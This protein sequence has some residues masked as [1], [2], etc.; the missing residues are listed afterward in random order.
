MA[1]P[2]TTP[3]SDGLSRTGLLAVFGA[4]LMWGAFPLYFV[5]TSP[6]SALEVVAWRVV[7]S[8]IFCAILLVVT[9]TWRSF[10][11]LVRNGSLMARLFV[12]GLLVGGNWLI[13]VIAV[14]SG[15][16]LEASLGYF[17][18]PLVSV[19]LGVVVLHEKLRK[20]QWVAVG[21]ATVAVLAMS[22]LYGQVPWLALGLAFTFGFYGLVKSRLGKGVTALNSLSAETLLL[23]PIALAVIAFINAQGNLTLL[24]E[25]TS[26]FWVLA[27]S[28]IVT[29]VPL[30]CFAVAAANLPLSVV[31]MVQYMTPIMQFLIAL[32]FFHEHMSTERWLGFILVWVAVALFILDALRHNQRRRVHRRAQ[33]ASTTRA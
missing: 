29:G 28:G 22:I 11:T 9:G 10:W 31:G 27:F 5:L 24:S 12:A 3:A 1:Q 23:S 13:Y 2:S 6:A 32:L 8:L 17:I 18:N 16:T 4:Y 20:L 19:L 30:L 21:I 7:F 14:T 33:V 26:H 15:N 25:G